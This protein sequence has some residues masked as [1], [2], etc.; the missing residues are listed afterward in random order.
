MIIKNTLGVE[1]NSPGGK[2]KK[3]TTHLFWLSKRAFK[4]F[5]HIAKIT[6]KL[7]KHTAKI[8]FIL[9]KHIVEIAF[10]FFKLSVEMAF[11]RSAKIAC[12]ALGNG[13]YLIG[14]LSPLEVRELIPANRIA[15]QTTQEPRP[16][17]SSCIKLF[18]L[19]TTILI[20]CCCYYHCPAKRGA[21]VT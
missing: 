8:A 19:L 18:D 11:K 20:V 5:K 6:F 17:I 9:F 10:N 3:D 4:F 14:V 13:L 7:F 2:L 12:K 16:G 15:V 1:L 21:T